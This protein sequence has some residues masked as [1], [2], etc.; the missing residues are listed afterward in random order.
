MKKSFSVSMSG[1]FLNGKSLLSGS[2]VYCVYRCTHNASESKVSIKE[3]IYIGESFDVADRVSN[4]EKRSDWMK[5]LQYGE[6]LCYSSGAVNSSDGE[7]VEAAM[8]YKHKPVVNVEYK[9][10]F[11]YDE[12]TVYLSGD[13][14]ELSPAF[15]VQSATARSVYSY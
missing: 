2:G 13:T 5:K 9:H 1:Y 4:H 8:I 15:T 3:L 6:V 14:A 12:T 11:P 7:R 10:S